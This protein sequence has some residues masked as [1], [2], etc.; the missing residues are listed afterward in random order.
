VFGQ[1]KKSSIDVNQVVRAAMNSFMSPNGQSESTPSRD[2]QQSNGGNG[3]L[4]PFGAVA[5]GA[6][7]A[8]T[9]RAAFSRARRKLDLEQVADAVEQ[10]LSD[11]SEETERDDGPEPD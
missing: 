3:R 9:A 10:R 1:K 4:G 8:I 5:V 2:H 6:A 7:L 11:Q